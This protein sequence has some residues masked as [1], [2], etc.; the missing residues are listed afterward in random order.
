MVR[1]GPVIF[2]EK[3]VEIAFDAENQIIIAVWKGYLQLDDV[4]QGC[5]V[6]IE[7]I[8]QHRLINH[9]SDQTELRELSPEVQKYL[10][11][12]VFP[13]MGEAGLRKIAIL[14][15]ADIFAQATVEEV[16]HDT[17][18]K[19]GL[20]EFKTFHTPTDCLLWLND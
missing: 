4:R 12:E 16:N 14:V 15:S 18:S 13:A 6:L 1:N 3:Y 7:Y 11:D 19:V 10:V 5:D 9:L 8:R 17:E 2:S 20:I